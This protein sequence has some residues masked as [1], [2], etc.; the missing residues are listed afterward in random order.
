MPQNNFNFLIQ[1]RTISIIIIDFY[2]ILP[3]SYFP[4]SLLGK[5]TSTAFP[6][7]Y[8]QKPISSV[9][10]LHFRIIDFYTM[11]FTFIQL[12]QIKMMN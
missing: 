1:L 9:F 6:S 3:W 5:I 4:V 12:H 10:F 2:L 7:Y 11:Y 8:K